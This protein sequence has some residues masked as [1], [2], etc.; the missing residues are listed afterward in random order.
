MAEVDVK[1]RVEMK[2]QA[3]SAHVKNFDEVA[4]GYTAS[5]AVS[6]ASR[7]LGCKN[8][9]CQQ[10]CPVNI[11]IPGF[12]SKIKA[13]DFD[14]AY[15]VLYSYTSLPAVCGRVCPQEKNCEGS[16]IRGNAKMESQPIAI[17]RLERF[18]ADYRREH[19]K[20]IST[21]KKN[22]NAH[23]VAVIGSGPSGLT[24]A[25]D[26]AKKGY[27]VTVFEGLH[28]EGG[29]LIYGIPEFRLPK[30]I[31]E[32]EVEGLKK[33]GVKFICNVFVGNSVTIEE[34]FNQYK[35]ERIYVATGAGLPRFMNIN[36]ENLNGVYSAN[37]FLTRVNLM[38]AYQKDSRTP[39][40]PLEAVAVVGGGNVA[41]DAVRTS[42]RLGA[43]KA[44]II[45]RRDEKS[46][47]ARLE[48]VEHAKEEGVDFRFFCNPVEIKSTDG[49]NVSSLLCEKME[50]AEGVNEKGKV[51]IRSTGKTEEFKVD[52]V[53]MALG[54]IPNSTIIST[55]KGL[56]SGKGGIIEINEVGKTS[57]DNIYAGGD[58][59]TGAATVI[60]AMRAG[61]I[62]AKAIDES[63]VK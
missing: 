18:V 46:M 62:A 5:Q 3:P 24:C 25:G 54:N 4:C 53:I 30:K 16:C 50:I 27:D 45:Y 61:K 31:V 33:F 44:Y 7:C 42:I 47:P 9:H 52:A 36:G 8:A 17:G 57:L 56:K 59:A 37:E 2:T 6:E 26:L 1:K 49:V 10:A 28:K 63:F 60:K 32:N 21:A 13:Q 11:D 38:K 35:F 12:I 40:K 15:D 22:K 48:E 39:V 58:C 14:A 51:E 34:L 41:M 20:E 23:K 19:P 29:V 55:T 43:K